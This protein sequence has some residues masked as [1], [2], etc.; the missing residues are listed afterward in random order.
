LVKQR[1]FFYAYKDSPGLG[2]IASH[3]YEGWQRLNLYAFGLDLD[4]L[5]KAVEEQCENALLQEQVLAARLAQTRVIMAG[6]MVFK[7][8]TFL[9]GEGGEAK[10]ILTNLERKVDGFRVPSADKMAK[11]DSISPL[12]YYTF[13]YRHGII[14]I[15]RVVFFEYATQMSLAGIYRDQDKNLI[16]ELWSSLSELHIYMTIP[17]PLRTDE[18]DPRV[19]INMFLIRHPLKEE[20]QSDFVEAIFK[21]PGLSFY[22]A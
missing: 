3:E 18:R 19:E 14:G 4:S 11:A 17:S 8:L 13:A 7:G 2:I 1:A 15:S 22:N 16:D 12:N 9:A 21:I 10:E 20:L 5:Q 6:G